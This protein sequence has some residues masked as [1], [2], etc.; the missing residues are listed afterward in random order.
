MP[1]WTNSDGLVVKLGT[2]EATAGRAGVYSGPLGG[3]HIVEFALNLVDVT[4]ATA[5][6]TVIDYNTK[7]PNGALIEKV[8]V[9]TTTAVTGTNATLNFGLVRSS[10]MTTEIDFDGLG[11]AAALTQTAMAAKGTTLTF[12]KGTSNAGALLGTSLTANGIL[13]ADYDTAAFTQGRISVR[14]YYSVPL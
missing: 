6:A 5:G 14:I 11:T 2:I 3:Q 9:E 13:V 1:I 12:I 7:I 10:D 8:E 4:S